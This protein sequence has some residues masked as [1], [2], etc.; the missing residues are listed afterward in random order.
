M[1]LDDC[2]RGNMH[3][4]ILLVAVAL[5]MDTFAV[6]VSG[7]ASF[8]APLAR[9][10]FRLTFHFGLFQALFFL[11]GFGVGGGI[12]S[13]IARWNRYLAFGLLAFVGGRMIREGLAREPGEEPTLDPSRGWRLVMLSVATSIDAMAVGLSFGVLGRSVMGAAILVGLV[14]CG[15]TGLGILLG[16]VLRAGVGRYAE[17]LGGPIL[18]AIGIKVLLEPALG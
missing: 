4:E 10:V 7:G 15:M 16:R 14:S 1:R 12:A 13:A 5:G 11:M 6:G 9:K 18:I 2:W 3:P 17:M 8:R